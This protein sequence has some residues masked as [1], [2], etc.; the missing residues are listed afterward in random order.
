ME[1]LVE[2]IRDF[3]H[4]ELPE[5]RRETESV[6]EELVATKKRLDA[7]LGEPLREKPTRQLKSLLSVGRFAE[8]Q[9][10]LV[11]GANGYGHSGFTFW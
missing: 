5:L 11:R 9:T 3:H 10:T 2:E 6:K 8:F 4:S 1:D 7:L